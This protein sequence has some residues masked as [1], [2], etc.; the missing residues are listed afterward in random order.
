MSA[1]PFSWAWEQDLRPRLK[2]ALI[3]IADNAGPG[4][5]PNYFQVNLAGLAR[6]LGKDTGKAW[7]LLRDLEKGSLL[8]VDGP[9]D[10]EGLVTGQLLIPHGL[11]GR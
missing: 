2:L 5:D 6:F 11:V 9:R 4:D 1:V 7:E 3:Y 8:R 10:E